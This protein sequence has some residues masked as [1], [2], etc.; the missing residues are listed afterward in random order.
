MMGQTKPF[1]YTSTLLQVIDQ[2]M[3]FRWEKVF[4]RLLLVS[5]LEDSGITATL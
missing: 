2:G 5:H 4:K 1:L 3:L